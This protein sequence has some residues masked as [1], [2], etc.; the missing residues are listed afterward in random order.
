M[1][2]KHIFVFV[3]AVFLTSSVSYA[4]SDIP[5]GLLKKLDSAEMNIKKAESLI[6][7]IQKR[8]VIKEA[9][10]QEL[11]AAFQAHITI[12]TGSAKEALLEAEKSVK[13]GDKVVNLKA[14]NH[15]EKIAQAHEKRAKKILVKSFV[16][17]VNTQIG[18]VQLDRSTLKKMSPQERKEFK[19][20]LHPK[21][22]RKIEKLHPDLFKK[23]VSQD[24]GDAVNQRLYIFAAQHFADNPLA[25]N[26]KEYLGYVADFLLPQKAEAAIG[27]AGVAACGTLTP[28]CVAVLAAGIVAV[29]LVELGYR[30]CVASCKSYQWWC[31]SACYVARVG[32]LT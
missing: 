16:I 1:F 22:K 30:K 25:C 31:K 17:Q 21:G 32:Y 27:A 13:R 12:L 26:A 23:D 18:E 4:Q 9:D 2:I 15:Y 19:Q 5:P 3:M 20:F 14:I 28:A 11:D 24:T 10:A 8:K 29:D 6:A 7:K